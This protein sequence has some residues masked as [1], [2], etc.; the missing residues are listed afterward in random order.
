MKARFVSTHGWNGMI[1][2]ARP[3][4]HLCPLTAA[5][6]SKTY[7]RPRVKWP[8]RYQNGRTSSSKSSPMPVLLS[9]KT[10]HSSAGESFTRVC[11]T[12]ANTGGRFSL[13]LS[14]SAKGSSCSTTPVGPSCCPSSTCRS[15]G[16]S[17]TASSFKPC[18]PS[19]PAFAESPSTSSPSPDRSPNGLPLK[20]CSS[21]PVSCAE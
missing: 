20:S 18:A 6:P 14:S 1:S 17:S 3:Q 5:P 19:Q 21:L 15:S 2:I 7:E 4:L 9:S 13:S 12:G 11:M 16:S 10:N 8:L